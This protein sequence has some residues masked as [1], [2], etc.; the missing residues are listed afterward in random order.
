[1][2][3]L[4]K[5]WGAEPTIG[6]IQ[7]LLGK[8]PHTWEKNGRKHFWGLDGISQNLQ[9][10]IHLSW[11]VTPQERGKATMGVSNK[12]GIS[13]EIQTIVKWPC[14]NHPGPTSDI[15]DGR[16]SIGK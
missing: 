8:S 15:P 6:C 1:M 9:M 12:F 3:R 5:V 13:S 11:R 10:G 16:S 14:A 4:P 7:P 2:G